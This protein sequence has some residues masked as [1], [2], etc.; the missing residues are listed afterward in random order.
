MKWVRFTAGGQTAYGSLSGDTNYTDRREPWGDATPAGGTH[1]PV[2]C[3]TGSAG[4]PENVLLRRHQLRDAHP[5]EWRKS[6]ASSRCFPKKPTSA[7]APA[8]P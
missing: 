6:E 5:R 8:T 2:G 7:T 3:E 1:R 4:D